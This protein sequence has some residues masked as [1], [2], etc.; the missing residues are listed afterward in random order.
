MKKLLSSIALLSLGIP[1]SFA[2]AELPTPTGV[3]SLPADAT[4]APP[5]ARG[6]ILV[7][8]T[9]I[10]RRFANIFRA[11]SALRRENRML[12]R[13][14]THFT[15]RQDA[16]NF[17]LHP[18]GVRAADSNGFELLEPNSRQYQVETTQ[19]EFNLRE[20]RSEQARIGPATSRADLAP[21]ARASRRTKKN[22]FWDPT[23]MR[24]RRGLRL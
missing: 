3:E 20:M 18:T 17:Y 13:T 9:C 5:C 8:D 23:N 12:S 10:E 21:I 4:Y 1:F 24:V 14:S 2:F 7:N 16:R 19:I 15:Q 6:D 11:D 22:F